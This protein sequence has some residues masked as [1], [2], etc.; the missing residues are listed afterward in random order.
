MFSVRLNFVPT[1]VGYI[2]VVVMQMVLHY[3]TK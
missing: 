2:I 1:S 3:I